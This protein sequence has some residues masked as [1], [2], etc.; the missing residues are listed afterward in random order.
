MHALKTLPKKIIK[1]RK[2]PA[3]HPTINKIKLLRKR[4]RLLQIINLEGNIRRDH[5]GLNRAQIDSKNLTLGMLVREINR[6]DPR[7]GPHI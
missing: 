4:P 5:R 1:I 7:P 3:H 2:S 6:P